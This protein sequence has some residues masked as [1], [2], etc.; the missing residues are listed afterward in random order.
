[1]HWPGFYALRITS[2]VLHYGD[3]GFYRIAS[4]YK[5]VGQGIGA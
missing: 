4:S 3:P 1:V 2:L 5:L